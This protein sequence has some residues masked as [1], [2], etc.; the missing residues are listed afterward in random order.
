L[1]VGKPLLEALPRMFLPQSD[2][3]QVRRL[4]NGL[5]AVENALIHHRL[6]LQPQLVNFSQ[7]IDRRVS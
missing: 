3:F 2:F 5:D 4:I 6:S 1:E 7:N